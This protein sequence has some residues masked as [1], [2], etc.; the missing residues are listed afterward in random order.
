MK[1]I[2]WVILLCNETMKI[3]LTYIWISKKQEYLK[4]LLS[5]T[6]N[7]QTNKKKSNL[8]LQILENSKSALKIVR[9]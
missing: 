1:I 5:K 6:K 4:N 7:K 3:K 2:S 8:S 9:C